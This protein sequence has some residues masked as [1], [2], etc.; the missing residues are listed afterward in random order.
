MLEH[1]LF[2]SL[3]FEN[4]FTYSDLGILHYF[5]FVLCSS[6]CKYEKPESE[7]FLQA[8]SKVG[9]KDLKSVYHIGNSISKDVAGAFGVGLNAIRFNEWFDEDF[10]DWTDTASI[11]TSRLSAEK[12]L[13]FYTWGRKDTS[14]G[15][16]WTEIWDLTD[17]LTLFGFPD[18]DKKPIKTTYIRN[19]KGDF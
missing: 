10:P 2:F 17:I 18:D 16:Q 13:A 15:L 3:L 7:I 14:T 19:V 11:Q 5:D 6:E 8:L 4:Y 12:Q 9:V 1:S